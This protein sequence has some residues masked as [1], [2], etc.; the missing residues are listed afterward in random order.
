MNPAQVV[1]QALGGNR[2]PINDGRQ[3]RAPVIGPEMSTRVVGLN[4]SIIPEWDAELA[5]RRSYEVNSIAFRC[6]VIIAEKIASIPFKAGR[7]LPTARNDP[8]KPRLD[9]PLARLLG[10][11]PGSPNPDCTPVD[12][13]T[14]GIIQ[15][16]I[17]GRFAWEIEW[18]DKIGRSPVVALW[19]LISQFVWPIPR[20]ADTKLRKGEKPTYFLGFEYRSNAVV[21]RRL[22]VDQCFYAWRPSQRDFH[23]PESPFQAASLDID[24]AVMQDMYD[25][26][27]LNNNGV[28]ATAVTTGKFPSDDD[29][30]AFQERWENKFRGPRNAG[31]TMFAEFD[32]TDGDVSK[33]LDVKTIGLSQRDSEAFRRYEQKIRGICIAL[34]VPMSKLDASGRTFDNAEQEDITWEEETIIPLCE[35]I[36]QAINVRLAP[37]VGNEVGWF[38]LSTLKSQQK[39]R[40]WTPVSPI[41]AYNAG[42]MSL[43]RTLSALGEEPID[44]PQADVIKALETP[45]EPVTVPSGNTPDQ[46]GGNASPTDVTLPTDIALSKAKR[47]DWQRNLKRFVARAE[48]TPEELEKVESERRETLWRSIDGQAS[49]WEHTWEQSFRTQFAHQQA[50]VLSRLDSK[51]GRQWLRKANEGQERVVVK[52][53]FDLEYWRSQ[54]VRAVHGLYEMVI[55]GAGAAAVSSLGISFDITATYVQELITLRANKLAGFVTQTTYD[56]ITGQMAEGVAAGEGIPE[57]AKRIK[58]VFDDA[59]NN[60]ATTI[61]RTEVVSGYNGGTWAIGKA[62]P[63]DVVGGQEWLTAPGAKHPRHATYAGLDGQVR[64]IGEKF[65]VG[66]AALSYPGDPDGPADEVIQCRCSIAL[67]TPDAFAK[68]VEKQRVAEQ[69][70]RVEEVEAELIRIALGAAVPV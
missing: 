68:R 67:L 65:D 20:S 70:R 55:A 13:W 10:P 38:D 33:M 1:R 22:S 6:A 62:L 4:G 15:Y 8:G 32:T 44:D 2:G 56:A 64:A 18:G 63:T 30:R 27:F 3:F 29:F 47:R 17:T 21:P 28:P 59:S 53:L 7:K 23:Q 58:D 16:L 69:W 40:N 51:K 14:H 54:T 26:A 37:L 43:N 11:P 66:G 34:G 39:R 60:R 41:D 24:V 61:A 46:S 36:A 52:D 49:S 48:P 50:A 12:L 31:R 9:A 19:P 57:L 35:R 45:I 42:I 25:R 5:V